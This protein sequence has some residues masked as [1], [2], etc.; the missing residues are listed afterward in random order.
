MQ[1]RFRASGRTGWYLRVLQPGEVQAAGPIEVSERDPAGVT[2]LDAHLAMGDFQLRAPDAARAVV[3][4]PALAE[5]WRV[6]ILE[7]LDRKA[8]ET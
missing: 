6:P 1:A 4:H 7:R 5:R 3:M 8:D 2:V